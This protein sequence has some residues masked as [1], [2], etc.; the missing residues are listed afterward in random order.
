MHPSAGQLQAIDA[1]G[2]GLF[3]LCGRIFIA[4][5][6]EQLGQVQLAVNVKQ[7]FGVRPDELDIRKVQG[8]APQAV[9][10]EANE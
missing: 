9:P 3:I 8:A 4:G 7:D 2:K 10:I 5:Q 1:Q 6:L